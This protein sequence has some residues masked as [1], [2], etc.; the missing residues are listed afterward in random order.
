MISGLSRLTAIALFVLAASPLHA[1]EW[2]VEQLMQ[3]LREVK[4][5]KARF[6]E[7]KQLAIVDKPLESSGTL[8]YDADAGRLEKRVLKPR[9]ESLLLEGDRLTFESRGQRRTMGVRDNA[10][11]GLFVESI[12][13]TLAGDLTTLKRLFRVTL[14]G[15]EAKWRL[16]LV[17]HEERM[18]GFVTEVRL[19]GRRN[20]VDTIEFL[21]PQGDHSVM[22]I[23]RD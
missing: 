4:Q 12:R 20:W 19:A 2:T 5:V 13:S 7:R 21:E 15:S 11:V 23:Q 17:P 1:A 18:R 6:V 14:E 22:S 9:G 16:V 10:V 8:V 3:T